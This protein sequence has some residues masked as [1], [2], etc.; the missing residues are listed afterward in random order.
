MSG[1]GSVQQQIYDE[2]VAQGVNPAVML[3]I[4]NQE[5]GYN[6][7]AVGSSGEVGVFQLMPATAASVGV[8]DRT[9]LTQ[10]IQ[11]GVTYFKQLLNQFGGSISQALAAYNAGP[12][13]VRSGNIPAS[14]QSYVSRILAALGLSSSPAP[15]SSP[16][17]GAFV[18]V[19]PSGGIELPGVSTAV[20]VGDIS[21]IAVAAAAL[22]L[23]LLLV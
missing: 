17:P 3:A 1:T 8:T 19:A 13:A 21:G 18:S 12:G 9:N 10:N 15:S 4:A 2:A 20:S 5:S 22:G 11:G 14:T 6:Q 16:L 7:A 23:L